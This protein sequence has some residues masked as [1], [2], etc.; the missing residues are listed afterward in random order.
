MRERE[1]KREGMK[2]NRGKLLSLENEQN[3]RN[4]KENQNNRN[5]FNSISCN[6]SSFTY[7]SRHYNH[8]C[9]VR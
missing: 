4:V 1:D 5:N 2:K 8:V 6:N 7:S 9:Y 3:V